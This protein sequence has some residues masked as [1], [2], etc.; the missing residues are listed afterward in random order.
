MKMGHRNHHTQLMV[1]CLGCGHKGVGPP[2]WDTSGCR[3]PWLEAAH[4]GYL[5]I[6]NDEVM[7]N[8]RKDNLT[9][10]RLFLILI[11]LLAFINLLFMVFTT[12]SV[13]G[14]TFIVCWLLIYSRI[15]Q[16]TL[17]VARWLKEGIFMVGIVIVFLYTVSPQFSSNFPF[18]VRQTTCLIGCS[19]NMLS[20]TSQLETPGATM[21][22]FHDSESERAGGRILLSC[23]QASQHSI[24]Q[25][26]PCCSW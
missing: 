25:H 12:A 20:I 9:L 22:K 2:F 26:I 17:P 14:S 5:C 21:T 8:T 1:H 4:F 7:F 11:V 10:K 15:T 16:N 18:T 19:S 13:C 3:S 6:K 24:A 23:E